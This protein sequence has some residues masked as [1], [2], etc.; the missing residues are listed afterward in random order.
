MKEREEEAWN[1][2]TFWVFDA[3]NVGNLLFEVT[4]T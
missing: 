1:K 4:V 2:A 3:P